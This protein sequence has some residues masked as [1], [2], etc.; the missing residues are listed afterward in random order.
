MWATFSVFALLEV[1]NVILQIF[2]EKLSI[3]TV[4][5]QVSGDRLAKL[6]LNGDHASLGLL[7]GQRLVHLAL[8]RDFGESLHSFA[9]VR[10]G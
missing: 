2:D 1:A 5:L 10:C 8:W 7:I 9:F 6:S 3:F 4:F